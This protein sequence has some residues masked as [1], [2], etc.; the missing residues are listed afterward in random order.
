MVHRVSI[1]LIVYKSQSMYQYY[2]FVYVYMHITHPL[3]GCNN[4]RVQFSFRSKGRH[5]GR[6]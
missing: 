3:M 4:K 2:Q 5:Y 1:K 6:E